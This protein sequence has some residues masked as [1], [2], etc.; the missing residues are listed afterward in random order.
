M[1]EHS[2]EELERQVQQARSRKEEADRAL[3]EAESRLHQKRCEDSGLIGKYA[4]YRGRTLEIRSLTFW[5]LGSKV[6]LRKYVGPRILKDGSLGQKI[7]I[8]ASDNGVEIHDAPS[9]PNQAEA[10]KP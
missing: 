9:T 3:R 2:I 8:Y 7:E 4:S 6:S 5:E 10:G 1:S